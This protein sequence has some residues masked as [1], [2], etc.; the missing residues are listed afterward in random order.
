MLLPTGIPLLAPHSTAQGEPPPDILLSCC[1]VQRRHC[2]RPPICCLWPSS[3]KK[4]KSRKFIKFSGKLFPNNAQFGSANVGESYP[5]DSDLIILQT[6]TCLAREQTAD[7]KIKPQTSRGASQGSQSHQEGKDQNPQLIGSPV[8]FGKFPPGKVYQCPFSFRTDLFF[9]RISPRGLGLLSANQISSTC[10]GIQRAVLRQCPP[11][12]T[13]PL[14]FLVCRGWPP[15]F[16][17]T[18]TKGLLSKALRRKTEMGGVFLH[19]ESQVQPKPGIDC[20]WGAGWKQR[21][22]WE[23]GMESG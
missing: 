15:V 14:A 10:S 16:R 12:L 11:Q 2:T 17:S 18:A 5:S 8:H 6:N 22:F 19:P 1:Y 4:H 20:Y 3:P 9:I 7:K 23:A 21:K 13:K